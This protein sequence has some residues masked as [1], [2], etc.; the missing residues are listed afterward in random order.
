MLSRDKP[1][2]SIS[3]SFVVRA[4]S[5]DKDTN[6]MAPHRA[7]ES[8]IKAVKNVTLHPDVEMEKHELARQISSIVPAQS[9]KQQD[10]NEEV[11]KDAG[12]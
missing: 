6:P 4:F 11:A 3:K 9:S 7:R 8:K 12:G 5:R 10:D 2:G 1:Q